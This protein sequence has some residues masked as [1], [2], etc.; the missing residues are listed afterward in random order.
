MQDTVTLQGRYVIQACLSEG[1]FARTQLAVDQTTQER[2]VIKEISL[3]R[4]KDEKSIELFER[5]AKVL[6]ELDHP[7]IP[8]LID[9]FTLETDDGDGS[10]VRVYLVQ[11]LV[12]GKNLAQ[13]IEEG[14][15]FTQEE[16]VRLG[17]ELCE[18][19]IYLHHRDPTLLHRD[20]KPSNIMLCP[21]TGIYLIDFGA[22]RD[23]KIRS[24]RLGGVAATSVGTYGYMPFE[25]FDGQ[26]V[27]AS[28]IYSLGAT[29]IFLLSH[30]EPIQLMRDD[31]GLEFRNHVHISEVFS[32]VL[33][34]MVRP[35]WED[36]YQSAEEL[37]EDLQ[38]VLKGKLP[39]RFTSRNSPGLLALTYRWGNDHRILA[40]IL[41]T[42]ILVL[43]GGLY[44]PHRPDGNGIDTVALPPGDLPADRGTLP[45][46]VIRGEGGSAPIRW[47]RERENP[48]G[49][50]R[51][52]GELSFLPFTENDIETYGIRPG[53]GINGHILSLALDTSG[54]HLA[55]ES[56][57]AHAIGK[58]T[59]R[60]V[61]IWD[62]EPVHL[63]HVF[64]IAHTCGDLW[65]ERYILA[66]QPQGERLIYRIRRCLWEGGTSARLADMIV[67]IDSRSGDLEVRFI[68]EFGI[69]TSIAFD[70]GGRR[71]GVISKTFYES[72]STTLITVWDLASGKQMAK[73]TRAPP[74]RSQF[75]NSGTYTAFPAPDEAHGVSV[76]DTATQE[77]IFRLVEGRDVSRDAKYVFSHELEQIEAPAGSPNA[78]YRLNLLDAQTH[79][80][81]GLFRYDFGTREPLRSQSHQGFLTRFD[82]SGDAKTLGASISWGKTGGLIMLWTLEH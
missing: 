40:G 70:R 78:S 58:Y 75:V 3:H 62:L 7:K 33:D 44:R 29:L 71:L 57:E 63:E 43:G 73:I 47:L 41:L 13:L 64:L 46:I 5:E 14:R 20:I 69:I 68:E 74:D 18:I 16:V 6:A 17:L 61:S 1:E 54:Q 12:P 52:G 48:K 21:E 66:F 30:R 82:I 37:S 60:K 80:S 22:V 50:S 77:E 4:I 65:E 51:S 55:V 34:R 42:A 38:W 35:Q 28:D 59:W 19:L 53:G 81:M 32:V 8:K 2:C 24:A 36:R 72:P 31:M 11:S 45:T 10:D 56:A 25:Q 27:K 15:H 79:T 76:R 23:K 9:Y 49:R 67:A 26:A 39:P